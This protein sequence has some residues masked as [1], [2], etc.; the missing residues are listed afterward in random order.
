MN[1]QKSCCHK[2]HSNILGTIVYPEQLH[3]QFQKLSANQTM[4]T[5]CALT[6][7]NTFMAEFESKYIYPFISNISMLY[8]RY[9]DDIFMIWKIIHDQLK[10]FLRQLNKQYPTL[11]FTY[12]ISKK[13]IVFLDIKV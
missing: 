4:G 11:E 8:L 2:I 12:K 3:F 13:E 6:Y 5:I 1:E 7:A 10:T 9:I